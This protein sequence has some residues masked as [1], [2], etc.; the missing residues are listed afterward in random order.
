LRRYAAIAATRWFNQKRGLAL[1]V[2]TASSATGQLIFLPLPTWLIDHLGW[3]YPLAPSLIRLT[4]AGALAVLLMCENPSDIGL[5]PYGAPAPAPGDLAS[6]TAP[7][8]PH[9]SGAPLGCCAM[10]RVQALSGSCS[11]PS[12]FAA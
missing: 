2:L 1:G 10:F 8:R 5:G 12:S 11:P 4:F 9:R 7:H 6:R 3:R